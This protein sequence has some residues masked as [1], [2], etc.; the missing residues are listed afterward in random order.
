MSNNHGNRSGLG[1]EEK[2]GG[3]DKTSVDEM[4]VDVGMKGYTAG[5]SR[6]IC[7]R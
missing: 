5:W 4:L 3:W 1:I 2:I 7:I 6:A